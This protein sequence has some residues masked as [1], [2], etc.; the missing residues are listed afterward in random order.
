MG[1]NNIFAVSWWVSAK[2]T[3]SYPYE[4][5]YNTLGFSGKK[6]T[7]IPVYKDEGKD[8]DR[9]FIQWDTISLMSLLSVNVI[10]AYYTNAEK[11][12]SYNN[13]ITNQRYDI[14]YILQELN[15]LLSY[16]SDALHW[17]LQQI[18]KINDTANKALSS[19]GLIS[20]T[21]G[22][23]MHSPPS[24]KS[25]ISKI[26]TCKEDFM[27]MSRENALQAQ[28]REICT[29]QPKEFVSGTKGE[30]TIKNYL[31]G[32]YYFTVDEIEIINGVLHLYECKHTKGNKLPSEGDIK[33]GIMKMIL[34]T[35]LEDVMVDGCPI[36]YV[37]VL[38]L[39]AGIISNVEIQNL[40]FRC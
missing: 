1:N 7:I 14:N 31:G 19:Y 3:R 22:V 40:S 24:A 26:Y 13:K 15:S 10:I 30:I 35:N 29:T 21:L 20:S 11:N 9:D 36:D 34:Y 18:D 4:R 12:N 33:D 27:R 28:Q 37:P 5:V 39:T 16:Q 8:G 38:K 2:R 23:Q 25:R 17:N 6:V 32:Y